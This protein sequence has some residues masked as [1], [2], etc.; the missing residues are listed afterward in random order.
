M[1][2][3]LSQQTPGFSL[4][5]FPMCTGFFWGGSNESIGFKTD[6]HVSLVSALFTCSSLLLDR[7][8]PKDQLNS[9]IT[10]KN[11][12]DKTKLHVKRA[13]TKETCGY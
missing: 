8:K 2:E 10:S 3:Q 7:R 6:M 12:V 13:Q 1:F 11:Q 9:K 4:V 5:K